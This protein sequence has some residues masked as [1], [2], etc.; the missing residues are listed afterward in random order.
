MSP[1]VII[2]GL[3]LVSGIIGAIYIWNTPRY[4][5]KPLPDIS[6]W[7]EEKPRVMNHLDEETEDAN[8]KAA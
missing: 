3:P 4:A 8:A 6:A 1:Y 2:I 7:R 5:A